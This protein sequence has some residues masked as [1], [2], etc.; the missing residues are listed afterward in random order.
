M[1]CLSVLPSFCYIRGSSS[2]RLVLLPSN[3]PSHHS[4]PVIAMQATVP[5]FGLA[6]KPASLKSL[7]CCHH[8]GPGSLFA[9]RWLML[10]SVTGLLLGWFKEGTP[11]S[12][13]SSR[14]LW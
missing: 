8:A 4:S 5:P 11:K 3:A 14:A 7:R 10:C 1:S 9:G 2:A 13:A 12:L 6:M